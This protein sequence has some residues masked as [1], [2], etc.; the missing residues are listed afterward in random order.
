MALV[1]GQCTWQSNGTRMR[2]RS[3]AVCK[4]WLVFRLL[5]SLFADTS[6][7]SYALALARLWTSLS[8]IRPHLQ[9]EQTLLRCRA[10][11]W[12]SVTST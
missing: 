4:H 5:T 11:W 1:Q 2:W 3:V 8:A 10:R 6:R 9:G 7:F 12:S